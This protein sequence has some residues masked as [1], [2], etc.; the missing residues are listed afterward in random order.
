MTSSITKRS[1]TPIIAYSSF[2]SQY[3]AGRFRRYPVKG[4]FASSRTGTALVHQQH[5]LFRRTSDRRDYAE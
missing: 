3:L 4:H 2:S 5:P 1:I